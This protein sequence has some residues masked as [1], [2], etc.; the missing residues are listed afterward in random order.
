MTVDQAKGI[1]LTYR[2]WAAANDPAYAEALALARADS[3]LR[4]WFEAHCAAQEAIRS[5]FKSIAI[6]EGLKAQILSERVS[7]LAAFRQRHR[8]ALSV[9]ALIL[10]GIAAASL[11]TNL[12]PAGGP[13]EAINLAGFRG[14]MVTTAV[15]LYNMELETDNAERIR[16]H[17]GRKGAFNDYRLTSGLRQTTLTGCGVLEWQG[18]KVSMVCF[19][20]GKSLPAGMKSDLYL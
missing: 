19:R 16:E 8:V 11:W 7:W 13:T 9:A 2:P 18:R 12:R 20:S 4:R 6:P 3:E 10:I 17:L 1:L 14:R 15:R 5:N